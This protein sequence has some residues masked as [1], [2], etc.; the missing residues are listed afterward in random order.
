MAWTR[1][2]L[3]SDKAAAS[4][5]EIVT[6]PA[7]GRR[8]GVL[9]RVLR[10]AAIV[11]LLVL[12]LPYAIA[13]LYRFID[14]VSVPMLYRWLT[15]QRVERIWVP[16]S[17]ISSEVPVAAIAAEDGQFCRHHGVDFGELREA[18]ADASA[19]DAARGAST[20]TQQTVKNLFLW[21]GRSIIRKALELPLAL[22]FNFVVPKRRQLE[23]YLNIAEW[24]PDGEFGV[25]AGARRAFGRSASALSAGQAALLVSVLPNPR[26]RDARTPGPGLR[27]IAGIHLRRMPAARE[28][29]GCLGR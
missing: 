1:S 18:L 27:R 28:L 5:Q 24:G 10:F 3:F 26:Q 4:Q 7:S 25:E 17:Q 2:P 12:L 11:I 21:Q 23:I 13:P 6:L 22:W 19:G 9:V 15:F 8:R 14:P 29:D 16:L 20:I